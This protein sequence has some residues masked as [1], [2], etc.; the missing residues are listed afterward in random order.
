MQKGKFKSLVGSSTKNGATA[1]GGL[2]DMDE[3]ARI[4]QQDDFERYETTDHHDNEEGGQG[5]ILSDEDLRILTDRSEES[6]VRAEKG[7]DAGERFRTVETKREGDG[8]I[9]GDVGN[10]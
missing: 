4:L 9:L 3:L 1:A 5:M 7:L 6:Y 10:G 8:G 2:D